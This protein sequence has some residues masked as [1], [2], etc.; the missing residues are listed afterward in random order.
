MSDQEIDDGGPAFPGSYTGQDG[1]PVWSNGMSLRPYFAGLA[2]QGL[3]HG[4][5]K[6]HDDPGMENI[7]VN[8]P[9]DVADL[10]VL[11]ADTL[12]AALKKK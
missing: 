10:S 1:L 3:I 8:R 12:I 4:I 6:F 9:N 5:T 2:M 7:I 11:Y